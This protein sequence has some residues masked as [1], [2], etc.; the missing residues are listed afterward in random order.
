MADI[1][2]VAN[3]CACF[4]IL[5]LVKHIRRQL[6]ILYFMIY[7]L[8]GL[9]AEENMKKYGNILLQHA[10]KETTDFLKRLCTDYRPSNKPLVDQVN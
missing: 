7:N 2:S 4:F 5:Q 1:I 3:S 10:P 9:Q 8:F 6:K